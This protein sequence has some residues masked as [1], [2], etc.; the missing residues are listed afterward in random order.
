V[1]GVYLGPSVLTH[2]LPVT[3]HLSGRAAV[4]EGLLNG[5]E[6]GKTRWIDDSLPCTATILV[7]LTCIDARH[8]TRGPITIGQGETGSKVLIHCEFAELLPLL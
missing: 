1:T 8:P 5:L 7:S 4:D 6:M 3:V 2:F